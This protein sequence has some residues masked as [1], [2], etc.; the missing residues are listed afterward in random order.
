MDLLD[1]L[2]NRSL[3]QILFGAVAIGLVV[4]FVIGRIIYLALFPS[5]RTWRTKSFTDEATDYS[6]QPISGSESI[7]SISMRLGEDVRDV[8]GMG[9]SN[10]QINAVL[11]GKHSLN[12]IYGMEPQG[13]TTSPKG[14]EILAKKGNLT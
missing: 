4:L 12:E 5:K 13:N 6:N 14:K 2:A 8:W 9:Y 11:T 7:G 10:D 1:I 3:S